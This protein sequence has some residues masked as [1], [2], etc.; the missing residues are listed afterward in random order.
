M[1]FVLADVIL[2]VQKRCASLGD[3][4]QRKALV[5]VDLSINRATDRN[6]KAK[7]LETWEVIQLPLLRQEKKNVKNRHRSGRSAR[8]LAF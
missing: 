5:V 1:L 4:H 8:P 7:L 6:W 3:R 2:N